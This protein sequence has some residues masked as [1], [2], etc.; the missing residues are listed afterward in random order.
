MTGK[1]ADPSNVPFKVQF[2]FIFFSL[3]I[4]RLNWLFFAVCLWPF[5]THMSAEVLE[6]MDSAIL[7]GGDSSVLTKHGPSLAHLG[8]KSLSC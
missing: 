5:P 4:T 8:L 3:E 1:F 2:P 7:N 6:A